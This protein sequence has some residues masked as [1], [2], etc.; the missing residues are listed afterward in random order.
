MFHVHSLYSKHATKIV[1]I[2]SDNGRKWAI[3]AI[4]AKLEN[5]I[6]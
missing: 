2:L 4:T 3:L 1:G 5:I 6:K